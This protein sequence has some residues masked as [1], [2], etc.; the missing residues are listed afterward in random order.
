MLK[1]NSSTIRSKV[2]VLFLKA[3]AAVVLQK[4]VAAITFGRFV[5]FKDL[6]DSFTASEQISKQMVKSVADTFSVVDV[7]AL[8]VTKHFTNS[9]ST[10]ETVIFSVGLVKSDAATLGDTNVL[11][12]SKSLSDSSGATDLAFSHTLTK[13]LGDGTV[14]SDNHSIGLTRPFTDLTSMTDTTATALGKVF[15]DSTAVTDTGTLRGQGYCSFSY[16]SDDYV[17]YAQTI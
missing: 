13:V 6:T 7:T 17:G 10:A 5:I 9:L 8:G 2:N 14:I 11:V 16:L 3:T 15:A 4:A 12:F 1:T